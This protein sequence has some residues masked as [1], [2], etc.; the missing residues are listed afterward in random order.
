MSFWRRNDRSRERTEKKRF[1]IEVR[2]VPTPSATT[3]AIHKV[4]HCWNRSDSRIHP[5]NCGRPSKWRAGR[6]RGEAG[7]FSHRTTPI[8][9]ALLR[10]S[11]KPKQTLQCQLCN[12]K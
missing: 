10:L 1:D 7:K 9:K 5:S 11:K 12:K 3:A 6:Q 2:E 4:L 8:F